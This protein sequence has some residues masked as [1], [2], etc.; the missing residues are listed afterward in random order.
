MPVNKIKSFVQNEYAFSFFSKI[1]GVVIAMLYSILYNRYLGAVLKGDAAIISN[2]ISIISSFTCFG[3]YQ[4]YPYYRRRDKEVFYPFLNNMTSFNLLLL[5]VAILMCLFVNVDWNVRIAILLVPVYSFVRHINYMALVEYPTRRNV[6]GIIIN[7][8]DVVI[9]AFFFVFTNASYKNL[10]YILLIQNAINLAIS[11][12]NLKANIRKL[13]FSLSQIVKYMKFGFLPMITL[14]LMTVNYRIDVLMLQDAPNVGKA[15]IGVYSVGVMLAEKVWLLPDSMKDILLSHLCKGADKEEV[16]KIIRVSLALTL[17]LVVGV[18]ILGKPFI[19]ILYGSA[20][21]GAYSITV[22][23]LLGVIGMIFYKMVYAY[24]VSQGKRFIN[25]ILL[26]VSALIN[27][28][29]NY[30][31][32]PVWGVNGAAFVSVASYNICG[33]AFLIYFHRKTDASYKEML[34][35][36]RTDLDVIK[37]YIKK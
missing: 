3:M 35:L 5:G 19:S 7:V 23:M 31:F 32:I 20:Y 4:A 15:A 16:S 11:Y 10:I 25:M 14:F 8:A 18:A 29:G 12:S 9:V 28:I 37:R 27:V 6:S 30:F 21:D 17:I 24:N 36:K 33:I 34:I 26:A 2:Y 1:V 22:I 13:R